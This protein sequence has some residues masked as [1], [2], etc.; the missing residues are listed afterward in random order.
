MNLEEKIRKSFDDIKDTMSND[1][2]IILDLRIKV[3]DLETEVCI[4]KERNQVLRRFW[5][6]S[7][8]KVEELE[9][10][11]DEVQQGYFPTD[12]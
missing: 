5:E 3:F 1:S 10:K 4:L 6:E 12:D 2:Q 8:K 11:L 7:Q 9:G